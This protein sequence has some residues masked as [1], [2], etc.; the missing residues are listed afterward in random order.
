MLTIF[1]CL[2][3]SGGLY[4][5]SEAQEAFDMADKLEEFSEKIS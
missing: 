1:I 3:Y 4:D 2:Y 5:K